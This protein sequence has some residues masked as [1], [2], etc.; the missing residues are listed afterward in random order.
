MRLSNA[1]IKRKQRAAAAAT[2]TTTTTRSL[3]KCQ[4]STCCKSDVQVFFLSCGRVMRTRPT[5]EHEGSSEFEAADRW[6]SPY[7]QSQR[8]LD[9]LRMVTM[10]SG[11]SFYSLHALDTPR[12]FWSR[13]HAHHHLTNQDEMVD[14]ELT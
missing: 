10:R 7:R 3:G 5:S 9:A 2:T 11:C 6:I 8:L 13:R 12:V 4:R 1:L 14:F